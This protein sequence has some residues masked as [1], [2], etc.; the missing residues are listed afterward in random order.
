MFDA[1]GSEQSRKE[2]TACRAN[3]RLPVDFKALIRRL[4]VKLPDLTSIIQNRNG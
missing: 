1:L 2:A 3:R 4:A